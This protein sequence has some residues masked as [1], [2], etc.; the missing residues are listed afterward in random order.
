MA[1]T[2]FHG[3]YLKYKRI[4]SIETWQVYHAKYPKGLNYWTFRKLLSDITDL[5]VEEIINNPL[6]FV[7]PHKFGVIRMIG[8]KMNSTGGTRKLRK[9]EFA[10]TNN[11]IYQMVWLRHKYKVRVK[12]LELFNF[13][14]ARLIRSYI[15]QCIREDKFYNWMKLDSWDQ[16][17]KMSQ[18]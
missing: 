10:R 9:I 18:Y 3:T 16:V 15:T 12:Y 6:G 7:L 14:T 5:M 11:Y 13:S 2:K 4:V 8:F 17:S 1:N